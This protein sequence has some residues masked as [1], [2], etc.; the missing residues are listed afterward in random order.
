[1]E[2]P[3]PRLASPNSQP[4]H[5]NPFQNRSLSMGSINQQKLTNPV[6]DLLHRV[7]RGRALVPASPDRTGSLPTPRSKSDAEGSSDESDGLARQS[8]SQGSLHSSSL[9]TKILDVPMVSHSR[10]ESMNGLELTTVLEAKD[11]FHSV[12]PPS[13]LVMSYSLICQ[14]YI[15]CTTPHI[16]LPMF[17][18]KFLSL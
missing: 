11:D 12:S 8:P 5:P 7:S 1:M 10:T 6:Q 18:S 2:L 13:V 3:S 16:H 15:L 9:S 17:E 4:A 14:K